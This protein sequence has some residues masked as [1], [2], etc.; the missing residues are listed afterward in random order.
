MGRL[1]DQ[2]I[3]QMTEYLA[4]EGDRILHVCEQN[5]GY[6]HQTKRLYDSYGY[7]VYYGGTLK[8]WGFLSAAPAENNK[9]NKKWYGQ[10][11]RGRE[12]IEKFLRE[13]KASAKGF[14]L[15][16]AAA[17]PYAQI[18]ETGGGT[19]HR[20]YQVI[21]LSFNELSRLGIGQVGIIGNM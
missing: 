20:K 4:K 11:L 1:Y 15:V 9:K 5:K 21:S 16:I 13:F 18:L 14:D 17:M 19:L 7:G 2:A 10:L 6:R 8:T 12:E 3:S